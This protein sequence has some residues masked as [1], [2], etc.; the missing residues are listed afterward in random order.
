MWMPKTHVS[1]GCTRA[2]WA[3]SNS[4]IRVLQSVRK[5]VCWQRHKCGRS[6]SP[7]SLCLSLTAFFKCIG[8]CLPVMIPNLK[9]SNYICINVEKCKGSEHSYC[10]S[11]KRWKSWEEHCYSGLLIGLARITLKALPPFGTHNFRGASATDHFSSSLQMRMENPLK[12][13]Q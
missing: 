3:R 13:E 7:T 12:R 9:K 8:S 4:A 1:R 2:R 6:A 10:A 11:G 5:E